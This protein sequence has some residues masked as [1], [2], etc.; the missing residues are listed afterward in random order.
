MILLL[1]LT[2]LAGGEE[3][4]RQVPIDAKFSA[5]IFKIPPVGRD[6]AIESR[7]NSIVVGRGYV[8]GIETIKRYKKTFRI[9]LIDQ[10]YEK[11]NIKLTFYVYADS[12]STR[13]MLKE[14]DLF[15]FSGQLVAY[16]PTNNRRDNYILD[17]ILE[18]GAV[19]IQ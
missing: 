6:A 17:I 3:E 14:K 16:T 18:K 9:V 11:S 5:D 4:I 12:K 13:A 2:G 10:D 19:L 1:L 15:E 8:S 7:L